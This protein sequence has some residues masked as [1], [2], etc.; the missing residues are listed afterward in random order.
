MQM[1][2]AWICRGVCG[3]ALVGLLWASGVQSRGLL[4]ERLS[5]R[6][7]ATGADTASV[8]GALAFVNVALGG[9]RGTLVDLLW[10]RAQQLQ[11]AGRYVELVPLAEGIAALEPDNAEVWA[12]HAWNLAFNVSAMM[13]RAED[14]WRWVWAGVD[15]LLRRGTRMNVREARMHRELSWIFQFKMGTDVDRAAWYYRVEWARMMDAYLEAGGRPPEEGSLSEEELQEVLGLDAEKMR[16]LDARFGPMDWRV[17]GSHA[18]YWGM[19]GLARATDRDRLLCRRAVYQTLVQMVQHSGRIVED[20]Q[21]DTY[22]GA[23]VANVELMAGTRDFL[24]ET[25]EQHPSRNVR[26]ALIGFLIDVLQI[27]AR[28]GLVAESRDTYAELQSWFEEGTQLPSY[29][30]AVAGTFQFSAMPWSA[31][32]DSPREEEKE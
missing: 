14:R 13:G 31:L 6:R 8:P 21:S 3:V 27:Y 10:L 12:Y 15:L 4:G 1:Q 16:A 23:M 11:D 24:Q 22:A 5:M 19:E 30:E 20:V 25:C 28:E 29:Q 18:V 2:K 17:P 26:V 9:F 32:L 7:D